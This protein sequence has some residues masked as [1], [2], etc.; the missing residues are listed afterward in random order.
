MFGKGNIR[1]GSVSAT[2]GPAY[3]PSWYTDTMVA[4]PERATLTTSLDAEGCLI[5]AGLSGLTSAREL[6]LSGWSVDVIDARRIA[7]NS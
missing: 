2:E 1:K 4:V 3:A 7:W 5:G 6:A